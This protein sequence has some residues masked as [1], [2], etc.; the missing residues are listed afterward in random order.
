MRR[1]E[2]AG[3][4]DADLS[5]KCV[6]R[7]DASPRGHSAGFPNCGSL[8]RLSPGT[9]SSPPLFP[10]AAANPAPQAPG[11]LKPAFAGKAM[12][13][14]VPFHPWPRPRATSRN[15]GAERP[16]AR[17][18]GCCPIARQRPPQKTKKCEENAHFR[19]A[20]RLA[21]EFKGIFIPGKK[22]QKRRF[23]GSIMHSPS[24]REPSPSKDEKRR[25]SRPRRRK[26]RRIVKPPET[27]RKAIPGCTE[28]RK[29]AS[30]PFVTPASPPAEKLHF[31]AAPRSIGMPL[32]RIL[33]RPA[34]GPRQKPGRG[35]AEGGRRRA[36]CLFRRSP[37]PLGKAM[38]ALS[39]RRR[40]PPQPGL[41]PRP[42]RK[43][44]V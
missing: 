9:R 13:Q 43:S 38:P 25:P 39:R 31:S 26:P 5:G 10:S 16:G 28:G 33:R 18:G 23:P 15:P 42:D 24:V 41:H 40:V 32:H 1:H 22:R 8:A 20:P 34:N 30:R 2:P 17:G 29:E 7:E 36:A 35:G 19:V 3:R 4:P 27:A 37:I 6:C 44:V 21:R 11:K 12:P 14:N